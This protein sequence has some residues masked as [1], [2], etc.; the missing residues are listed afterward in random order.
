MA[1]KVSTH[2]AHGRDIFKGLKEKN[3]KFYFL[4]GQTATQT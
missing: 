3:F 4:F 2:A 1:W